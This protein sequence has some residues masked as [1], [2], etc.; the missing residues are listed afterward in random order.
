[1]SGHCARPVIM[2]M[3][4][5][6]RASRRRDIVLDTETS[7]CIIDENNAR[8]LTEPHFPDASD[9][10]SQMAKE[11]ADVIAAFYNCM[12]PFAGPAFH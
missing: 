1:M 3:V 12:E 8:N 4:F 5:P 2:R 10:A 7:K 6:N 9:K 11:I